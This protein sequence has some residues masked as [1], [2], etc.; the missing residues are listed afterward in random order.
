MRQLFVVGLKVAVFQRLNKCPC[1]C[2]CLFR[3][4][5]ERGPTSRILCRT[6][7]MA[8]LKH[9][10]TSKCAPFNCQLHVFTPK[11]WYFR[12]PTVATNAN[13]P[14]NSQ[15]HYPKVLSH[16]SLAPTICSTDIQWHPVKFKLHPSLRR[17]SPASTRHLPVNIPIT[18]T[19][20]PVSASRHDHGASPVQSCR[21]PCPA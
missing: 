4:N 3:G 5:C 20:S 11:Q 10:D 6:K 1:L 9:L 15:L 8:A 18:G 13:A 19:A 2:F 7:T 21:P 16:L 12:T 14:F 17:S